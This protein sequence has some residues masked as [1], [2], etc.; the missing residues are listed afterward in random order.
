M[1]EVF[2]VENFVSLITFRKTGSIATKHLGTIADFLILY[3]KNKEQLKFK[4]LFIPKNL[5]DDAQ[6]NRIILSNGKTMYSVVTLMNLTHL[7]IVLVV[8]GHFNIVI[9]YI[10]SC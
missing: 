10:C 3:A 4:K 8:T 6:Y 1:D 9:I 2:G 7:A 5:S